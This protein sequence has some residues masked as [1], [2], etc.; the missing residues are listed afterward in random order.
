MTQR[1]LIDSGGWLDEVH[2]VL[3]TGDKNDL[4]YLEEIL[5]SEPRYKKIDLSDE[6]I[7]FEG[8]VSGSVPGGPQMRVE[9]LACNHCKQCEVFM[10]STSRWALPQDHLRKELIFR[11]TPST[12]IPVLQFKY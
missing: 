7:G 8:Y 6:G 10:K 4:R 12:L 2:W 5:A 1:N 3:N 11:P 9:D